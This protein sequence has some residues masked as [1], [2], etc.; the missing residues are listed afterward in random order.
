MTLYIKFYHIFFLISAPFQDLLEGAYLWNL[1]IKG[2]L[3]R[4]R[5]LLETRRLIEH[6]PYLINF[7]HS[8]SYFFLLFVIY[9][10]SDITISSFCIYSTVTYLW[11]S[12]WKF[13]FQPDII[14]DNLVLIFIRRQFCK[15]CVSTRSCCRSIIGTCIFVPTLP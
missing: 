5:R 11:M 13:T 7:D 3:I 10:P 8:T 14:T 1:N 15:L 4:D 12:R 9:G 2:A 6:L